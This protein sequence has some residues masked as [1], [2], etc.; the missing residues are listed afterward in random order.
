MI[1]L[2]RLFLAFIVFTNLSV[3]L[4]T[5]LLDDILK[6]P[7]N[8][9]APTAVFDIC[10]TLCVPLDV[11][12]KTVLVPSKMQEVFPEFMRIHIVH[13]KGQRN[14]TKMTHYFFPGFE[15]LFMYLLDQNWNVTFFSGGGAIRNRP[16]MKKYLNKA[17]LP[18]GD[19]ERISSQIDA[20]FA[21]KR[22]E[23]FSNDVCREIDRRRRKDL[24]VLNKPLEN[25]ILID[26]SPMD[27]APGQWPMISMR[28]VPSANVERG[29]WG[30]NIPDAYFKTLSRQPNPEDLKETDQN[31]FYVKYIKNFYKG[32]SKVT[33]NAPYVM[34]ILSQAMQE[35]ATQNLPLREAVA[36]TLA[37]AANGK[38]YE[39]DW[40][41]ENQGEKPKPNHRRQALWIEKGQE[42][43]NNMR[44]RSNGIAFD[45]PIKDYGDAYQVKGLIRDFQKFKNIYLDKNH[46]KQ[47]GGVQLVLKALEMTQDKRYKYFKLE[48]QNISP[49]DFQALL[50]AVKKFPSIRE[51]GLTNMELSPTMVD[52]VADTLKAFPHLE[53]LSFF[54][55]TFP[56]ELLRGLPPLDLDIF[57]RKDCLIDILFSGHLSHHKSLRIAANT[58]ESVEWLENQSGM[59]L[60][61]AK[62]TL[63]ISKTSGKRLGQLTT[64]LRFCDPPCFK[65][66]FTS[67]EMFE[68]VL[69]HVA[70][71]QNLKELALGISSQNAPKS[72]DR[73]LFDALAQ[74]MSLKRV[75]TFKEFGALDDQIRYNVAVNRV[76][77]KL[78]ETVA[79]EEGQSLQTVVEQH[80][81]FDRTQWK[82]LKTKTT[83]QLKDFYETCVLLPFWSAKFQH[84]DIDV[85]DIFKALQSLRNIDTNDSD[86]RFPLY[87][88]YEISLRWNQPETNP[89]QMAVKS[90]LN[91]P[92]LIDKGPMEELTIYPLKLLSQ[93]DYKYLHQLKER[94]PQIGIFLK[95]HKNDRNQS[96]LPLTQKSGD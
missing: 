30:N 73:Y 92:D 66:T 53:S 31:C 48:G 9:N 93:E 67:P 13:K 29:L 8:P 75:N 83:N 96:E 5:N 55:V 12:E 74:N 16:L 43:I 88:G 84:I 65:A 34:G 33:H 7:Q 89:V 91:H 21:Q 1:C 35:M 42:L 18:Y 81:S 49:Q 17:L 78:K 50:N 70:R 2:R 87:K 10:H 38:A 79:K 63:E 46:F 68:C 60:F 72:L 24:S 41:L 20:L 59:G 71:T 47:E 77:E 45:R 28:Y 37:D 76:Y 80:R 94:F 14:E 40:Y 58:P 11:S 26:N 51:F 64:L 27:V 61:P 57:I 19:P 82:S 32:L 15:S 39:R 22:F 36:F 44:Q 25:M 23:I 85:V 6:K 4:S 86:W 54:D 90:F 69:D 62:F 95:E 52:D 56:V 3:A